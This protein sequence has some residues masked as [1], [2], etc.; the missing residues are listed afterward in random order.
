MITDV[1]IVLVPPEAQP[2]ARHAMSRAVEAYRIQVKVD[3][4]T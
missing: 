3:I 2:G 1:A 4:A